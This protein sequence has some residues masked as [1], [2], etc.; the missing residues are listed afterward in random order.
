MIFYKIRSGPKNVKWDALYVQNYKYLEIFIC[1]Q[2][3]EKLAIGGFSLPREVHE[4]QLLSVLIKT[5]H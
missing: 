2:L 1:N 3:V 4:F 5:K